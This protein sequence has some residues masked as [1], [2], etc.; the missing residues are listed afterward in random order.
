MTVLA[1]TFALPGGDLPTA[2]SAKTYDQTMTASDG[3]RLTITPSQQ[4]H[5]SPSFLS[6]RRPPAFPARQAQQARQTS[7]SRWA[8]SASEP[9]TT[10]VTSGAEGASLSFSTSLAQIRAV[11]GAGETGGKN[12]EADLALHHR[13]RSSSL[14]LASFE[15]DKGVFL[16]TSLL[17]GGSANDI[18]THNYDG[19]FRGGIAGRATK[20]TR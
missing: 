15:I 5:C 2:R 12:A 11:H 8:A 16:G 20:P 1:Q 13:R 3:P 10:T 14:C 9:V 17:S 7:P 6:I 18:D 19:A 4:A